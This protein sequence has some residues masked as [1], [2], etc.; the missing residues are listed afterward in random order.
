[1]Y[2]HVRYSSALFTASTLFQI[3]HAYDIYTG[4]NTNDNGKSKIKSTSTQPH[5]SLDMQ[6]RQ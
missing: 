3:M 4:K 6:L 2:I 5:I 1:M